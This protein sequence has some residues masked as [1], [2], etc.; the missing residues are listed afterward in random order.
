MSAQEVLGEFLIATVRVEHLE[1][2]EIERAWQLMKKYHTT[3]MDLA[4]ATLVVLAEKFNCR[5][6]WTLDSDF[7]VYRFKGKQAFELLP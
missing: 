6:V 5:Q 1:G 7:Y 2:R 3:P 4:D